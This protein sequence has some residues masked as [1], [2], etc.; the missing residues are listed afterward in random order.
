MSVGSSAVLLCDEETA[1]KLSDDPIRFWIA[2]G[3]HTLRTAD[4]RH[5][6]I[7]LLPNERDNAEIKK[8]YKELYGDEK[9]ERYPGFTGFLASRMS[10]YYAY[11]NR[12]AD[13]LGIGLEPWIPDDLNGA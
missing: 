13:G 3:S 12:I 10:A 1:Y 7:P 5:M 9:I 11:A 2:A 6:E 4:R 8:Q